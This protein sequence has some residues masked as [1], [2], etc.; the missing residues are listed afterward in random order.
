MLLAEMLD[1]DNNLLKS[2]AEFG[3]VLSIIKIKEYPMEYATTK[4]NLGCVY[5]RLA[6]IRDKEANTGKI[7]SPF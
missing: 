3:K 5:G 7:N 6:K 2:I 1:A 4:N